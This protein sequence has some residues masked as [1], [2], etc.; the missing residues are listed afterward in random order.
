MLKLKWHEIVAPGEYYHL[1]TKANP[2]RNK[3]SRIHTHD[4]AEI[5]WIEAGRCVHHINGERK[6]ASSGD[7]IFI[8]HKD[9]HGF[10]GIGRDHVVLTNL[11]FPLRVF[12]D[13]A[14]RYP[15]FWATIYE[16]GGCLPSRIHLTPQQLGQFKGLAMELAKMPRCRLFIDRFILSLL[17]N[18]FPYEPTQLDSHPPDW[19]QTACQQ[20]KQPVYF[21]QGA[22]GFVKAA[23]RCHE[24]VARACRLHLGTTPSAFV[25]RVRAEHAAHQLR[26]TSRPIVDIAM[27]CGIQNLAHFYKI[28]KDVYGIPPRQYRLNQQNMIP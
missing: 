18:L 17:V 10:R 4:F 1:A 14:R 27:D 6:I 16:K 19:L 3:D 20:V 26:M 24:H 25:N 21:S 13:F 7:L 12:N 5:F 23:G 9:T 22:H 11:A 8:R 28:F 2:T 15:K